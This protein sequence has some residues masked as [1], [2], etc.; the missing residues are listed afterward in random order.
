MA[1]TSKAQTLATAA[2][3]QLAQLLRDERDAPHEGPA[4]EGSSNC[5]ENIER[6]YARRR[7]GH[8]F[9]AD[10]VR[11][12][13]TRYASGFH[14]LPNIGATLFVTTEKGP[15][16]PRAASLR[17]YLWRSADVDTLGEFNA[18]TLA[19]AEQALALVLDAAKDW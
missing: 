10:A 8:W 1:R 5:R 19:Q 14:D 12:F 15:H 2:L 11:F 6:D 9:D 17:V 13:R 3:A 18:H 16:D 7:R 4:F